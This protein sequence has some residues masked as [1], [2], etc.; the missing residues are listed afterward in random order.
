MKLQFYTILVL[1]LFFSACSNDDEPKLSDNNGSFQIANIEYLFDNGAYV[2]W[3]EDEDHGGY[4]FEILLV[5]GDYS[6]L[7]NPSKNE[8]FIY[9]DIYSHNKSFIDDEDEF[10]IDVY[11]I[12][13]DDTLE[14]LN[15]KTD[16]VRTGENNF[17]ITIDGTLHDGSSIKGSF[18]GNLIK[19]KRS[20]INI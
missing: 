10:Y 7:S 2:E 16:I 5:K 6:N 18:S 12:G 9:L 11:V 19:E 15:G 14:L 13:D 3:K 8:K 4:I 17:K 1:T 20:F